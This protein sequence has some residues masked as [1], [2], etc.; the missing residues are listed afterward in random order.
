[1]CV[2]VCKGGCV[3]GRMGT[4]RSWKISTLLE[5]LHLLPESFGTNS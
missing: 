5:D 3:G 2:C 1:M 4:E